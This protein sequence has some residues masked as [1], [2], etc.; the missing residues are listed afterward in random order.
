DRI[1]VRDVQP[2]VLQAPPGGRLGQFPGSE[3]NRTVTVLAPGEPL[4]LCGCDR[5][6]V[7]DEGRRR[8]VEQRVDPQDLQPESPYS[9]VL[10]SS[11][12]GWGPP[13]ACDSWA[14]TSTPH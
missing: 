9:A 6:S 14:F 12:S 5:L 10:P 8:V 11:A 13:A 1:E 7:D 2:C 3:G 4:L